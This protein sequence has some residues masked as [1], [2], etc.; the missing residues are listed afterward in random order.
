MSPYQVF[1]PTNVPDE[2][3]LVGELETIAEAVQSVDAGE[4]RTVEWRDGVTSRVVSEDELA[5]GGGE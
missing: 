5:S 4:D 2:V 1:Q 3:E